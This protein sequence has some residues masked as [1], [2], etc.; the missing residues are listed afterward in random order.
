MRRFTITAIE[1]ETPDG[2][3]QRVRSDYVEESWMPYLGPVTIMLARKIDMILQTEHKYAIDV[4]K[5]SEQMGIKPDDLIAACHRLVRYGLGYWGDK[6][7][8]LF[9]R[10][11]WPMVPDAIKTPLHRRVLTGLPDME[12][13]A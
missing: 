6:D 10:R 4:P 2:T 3:S 8:T 13:T 7:P 5:W 12:V 1:G 11:H 9:V